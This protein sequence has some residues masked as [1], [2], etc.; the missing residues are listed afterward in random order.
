[1]QNS[2]GKEQIDA[3]GNFNISPNNDANDRDRRFL[4]CTGRGR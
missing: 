3:K 2:G 1:M 4:A